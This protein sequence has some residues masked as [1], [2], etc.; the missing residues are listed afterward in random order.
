MLTVQAFERNLATLVLVLEA[1]PWRNKTLTREQF[2]A[3]M[4]KQIRRSIDVF[5]R[6]SAKAL[7]KRLPED[8]DPEMAS[9]IET[10]IAWRDRLAHRYLAENARPGTPHFK[11]ELLVE[12]WDVSKAFQ[13]MTAKLHELVVARVAEMPKSDVPNGVGEVIDA[14]MRTIVLGEEFNPESAM[15]T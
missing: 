11:P 4:G 9:E 6:A 1:K 13:E 15:T 2:R 12:L 3:S 5:Q 8:F 14:L 7:R 10:L